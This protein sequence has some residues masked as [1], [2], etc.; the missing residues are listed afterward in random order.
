VVAVC[1]DMECYS[2]CEFDC[3]DGVFHF[4][5]YDMSNVLIPCDPYP[6]EFGDVTLQVFTELI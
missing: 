2:S 4:E 5:I 1:K 3:A 6:E